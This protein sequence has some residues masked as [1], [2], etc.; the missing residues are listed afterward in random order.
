VGGD[1]EVQNGSCNDCNGHFG[2]AEAVVKEATTPL[3]NLLGI[4]NRYGVVPEES[5]QLGIAL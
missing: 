1:L 4:K 5:A 3:L 2:A